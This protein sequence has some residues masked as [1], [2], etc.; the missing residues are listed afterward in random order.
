MHVGM[1]CPMNAIGM[2]EML[3]MLDL[4]QITP[5]MC[6]V[7]PKYGIDTVYLTLAHFWVWFAYLCCATLPFQS[8][9]V[10]LTSIT[11]II[12]INAH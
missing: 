12:S 6:Q 11:S 7:V 2:S 5:H 10:Y 9:A 4:T 1:V 3:C 8:L